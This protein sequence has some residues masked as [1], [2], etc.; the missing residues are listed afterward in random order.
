MKQPDM[1]VRLFHSVS[2]VF[3]LYLIVSSAW[4]GHREL[5]SCRR[6]KNHAR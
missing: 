5:Q 1:H 6:K 4:S 2:Y 3:F